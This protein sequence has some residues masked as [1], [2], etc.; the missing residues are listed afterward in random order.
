MNNNSKVLN[1]F[2]GYDPVETVAWHTLVQSIINTS[3]VP[4]SF[5]PLNLRH[6]KECYFREHDIRQSNEFSFSRFLV[7]YLSSFNGY[8]L[9]V[10][11]DM[12][13]RGDIALL[14]NEIREKD[15]IA[16][17][18]VKHDYKSKISVKYLDK[19][20]YDYPRK[21]WSSVIL[22]NNE[23]PDNRCLTPEYISKADAATLHRFAWLKDENIGG[24]HVSW[25]WLVGEYEL[26]EVDFDIRNVHW[27]L[28]GPYFKEFHDVDFSD[29]W[30]N[31]HYEINFCLQREHVKK[32]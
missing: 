4:V 27:T 21:N 12:M 29:E 18:V 14:F 24:L 28:G 5:T 19:I 2:I 26:G 10:D 22:F 13:F 15:D 7:P 6:L 17:M 9:F 1:V 31:L 8:S 11:C 20:Q 23:H 30:R 3:S 32:K 16:V 25:N